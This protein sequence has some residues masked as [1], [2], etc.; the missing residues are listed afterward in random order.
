MKNSTVKNIVLLSALICIAQFSFS[1]N[2]IVQTMYTA[3][4]A[5]MLHNDTLFLY[6]GRDEEG[7]PKNGYLMREYRLFTTTDMVNW[8][9]Q[10]APLKISEIG[11]SAGDASAAQCVERNGKFYWYFS[12]MNR[13]PGKGGVSVGVAVA[14]SPYGHFKDALGKALVTND[15]TTYGKHSWDDLDPTAFID[16]DGQAYL[17][18]GNGACYW[19]KLKEDM[20]SLDGEIHALDVANPDAFVQKFTEAPWIYKRNKQY[21]LIYAA[22]FPEN[23]SYSTAKK[24]T[25]PWKAGRVLMPTEKGSNTNHPGII[26]YKGNAYFFYHN[27]ALPGGHSYNRSVAVEEFKYNKDG[28]LPQLRMTDDGIVKGVG[29]L[30]PYKRVE[31]ETMAFSQGVKAGEDD[32]TGVF[33]TS[34]NHNDYIRV[35]DVDFGGDGTS[36]FTASV[37]SRYDGGSIE[38]RTDGKDGKLIGTLR[39]PYIGEWDK[40]VKLATPVEKTKG[41]HDLYFIF[42][43]K[44]PQQL[45]NFDYWMFEK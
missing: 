28:T 40:W 31:A 42:K 12:T 18:W 44:Q 7:A 39:V 29:T 35:R 8:T 38:I 43:G 16:D 20:I 13:T 27:D 26:A 24:I 2:P 4:P 37:S 6:V 17:F 45:F 34:I 14:D 22:Q 23:I 9:D 36:K 1:Q 15:M 33:I 32:Q 21:Y 30:N 5:P 11:W 10:G 3:D 41:I 19:V 25:G